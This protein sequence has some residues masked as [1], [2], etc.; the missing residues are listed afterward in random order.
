M[1]PIIAGVQQ[2]Q[3]NTD[4]DPSVN[5]QMQTQEPLQKTIVTQAVPVLTQQ[6]IPVH[7]V[8]SSQANTSSDAETLSSNYPMLS[9]ASSSESSKQAPLSRAERFEMAL[10]KS[11]LPEIDAL[12]S[13]GQSVLQQSDNLGMSFL[14]LAF[15]FVRDTTTLSLLLESVP[16]E[17]RNAMADKLFVAV[18]CQANAVAFECLLH[19]QVPVSEAHIDKI[20]D[21]IIFLA[22]K[23]DSEAIHIFLKLWTS[24]RPY[25]SIRLDTALIA[26]AKNSDHLLLQLLLDRMDYLTPD[27]QEKVENALRLSLEFESLPCVKIILDWFRLSDIFEGDRK[28]PLENELDTLSGGQ[29]ILLAK[30]GYIFRPGFLP[31]DNDDQTFIELQDIIFG[32]NLNQSPWQKLFDEYEIPHARV[33]EA[34]SKCVVMNDNGTCDKLLTRAELILYGFRPALAK[35]LTKI[36]VLSSNGR[37]LDADHPAYMSPAQGGFFFIALINELQMATELM[38]SGDALMKNQIDVLTMQAQKQ[39]KIND[40][41]TRSFFNLFMRYVSKDFFLDVERLFRIIQNISGLPRP[42]ILQISEG[43]LR[44][45]QLSKDMPVP[46]FYKPGMTLGEAQVILQAER[47]THV[48]RVFPIELSAGL[49]STAYMA[50]IT[51]VSGHFGQEFIVY[52]GMAVNLVLHHCLQLQRSGDAL[53]QSIVKAWQ[54][55]E[56]YESGPDNDDDTEDEASIEEDEDENDSYSDNSDNSDYSDTASAPESSDTA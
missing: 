45:I 16:A 8:S 6:Q 31:L 20:P 29:L 12:I 21:Y 35:S 19:F 18:H 5:T 4:P 37:E 50:E 40:D 23:K 26:A 49:N 2:T 56:F 36:F 11:D 38:D 25:K 52:A 1:R 7:P 32:E 51:E 42:V 39:L 28:F 3:T 13:A 10:L 48:L 27:D 9:A 54:A 24:L 43:L 46:N 47:M 53:T 22:E 44:A 17:T 14:E 33:F 15:I 34:I 55:S 30:A 41:D